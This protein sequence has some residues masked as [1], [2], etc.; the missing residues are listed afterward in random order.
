MNLHCTILY[1]Q[2]WLTIGRILWA[3]GG[4]AGLQGVAMIYG[5]PV[6]G[7]VTIIHGP[8]WG[9]VTHNIGS[10]QDAGITIVYGPA[11][12]CSLTIIYSL[13]WVWVSP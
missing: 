4:Q 9:W 13:A 2:W 7:I 10:G 8:A 12:V 11:R 3:S 5:W 6:C 1:G